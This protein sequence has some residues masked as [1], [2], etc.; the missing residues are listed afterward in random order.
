V[1]LAADG[2]AALALAHEH[3][4]DLLVSDLSM[5][6]MG[7]LELVRRFRALPGNRL[8]PALLLT[9]HVA[10]ADRLAGFEA[11]AVDYLTKPFHPEELR[12]RVRAQ[13]ELRD[14]ALKLHR[15][16]KLASVGLLSAGLAH[17]LRNP[18]N[19]LLNALA[20]LR[21]LL[22][23]GALAA[24]TAAGELFTVVDGCADQIAQLARQLLV[25]NRPGPLAVEPT[26]L[27]AIVARALVMVPPL[28]ACRV[29]HDARYDGPVRCAGTLLTQ[30]LANL[31]ENGAHA[32]G[33]SG[34]VRLATFLDGERVV[35]EV[36]DSGPGVPPELRERVFEPFFTT[37]PPG[38]GT[39]LGLATSREVIERH[40][41]TIEVREQGGKSVFRVE[42]PRGEPAA[43]AAAEGARR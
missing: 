18:A 21:E 39:G 31:L 7:G 30:V 32:A 9:A 26:P 14:L 25:F 34:S 35:I 28:Q 38:Q 5:P 20:P 36:S 16:E 3:L 1:L 37:K 6:G 10:E 4:P 40:G 27:G 43:E 8:A 22:P 13:L 41:G 15:S 11:G 29:E 17:E 42:L 19:A 12:A 24:G 23:D 2:L 33:P